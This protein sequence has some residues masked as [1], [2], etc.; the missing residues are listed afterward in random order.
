MFL[1]YQYLCITALSLIILVSG[2][3]S[4]SLEMGVLFEEKGKSNFGYG[5]YF[6]KVRFGLAMDFVTLDG[7]KKGE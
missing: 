3:I 1:A 5:G 7:F 6:E 4:S 2:C